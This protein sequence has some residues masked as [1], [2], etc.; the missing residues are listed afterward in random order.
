MILRK[1]S[2]LL[3]KYIAILLCLITLLLTT[4]WGTQLTLSLINNVN[5]VAFDYHSGSLVRDVKLNSFQLQLDTL[6]IS[7]EGLSTELDF[8]CVWKNTLCIKSAK[9]DYF[10]LRYF[11]EHKSVHQV[12]T[13]Q[14]TIQKVR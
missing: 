14:S 10:T 12:S 8:S 1:I 2:L 9:A 11:D 5:G 13:I 3:S 6:E 4:P 7:V